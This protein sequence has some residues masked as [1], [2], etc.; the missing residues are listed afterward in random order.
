M[1]SRAGV[2]GEGRSRRL[3]VRGAVGVLFRV[4]RA[5]V[6]CGGARWGMVGGLGVV[7]GCRRGGWE[8]ESCLE[9]E[10]CWEEGCGAG[11]WT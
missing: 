2:A 4:Q 11:V 8:R 1:W 7:R 3:S 5:V 9:R 10:L 6:R